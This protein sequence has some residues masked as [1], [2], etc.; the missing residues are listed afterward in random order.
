MAFA[1][2]AYNVYW[3]H[4]TRPLTRDAK[5]QI[6]TVYV[7]VERQLLYDYP[8]VSHSSAQSVESTVVTPPLVFIP[9]ALRRYIN[10]NVLRNQH[11]ARPM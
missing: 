7:A 4:K 11:P 5:T 9:H 10:N 2:R 1:W 6:S 8:C 3:G